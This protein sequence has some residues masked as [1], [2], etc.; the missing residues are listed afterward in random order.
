MRVAAPVAAV[1]GSPA[2]L[3]PFGSKLLLTASFEVGHDV[4]V[5]GGRFSC[6]A[7]PAFSSSFLP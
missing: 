5:V 2:L 7:G 4:W 3:A 6:F 1:R